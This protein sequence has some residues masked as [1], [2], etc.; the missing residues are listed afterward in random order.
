MTRGPLLELLR[1][2]GQVPL[3]GQSGGTAAALRRCG[4]FV[5]VCNN[6]SREGVGAADR[7]VP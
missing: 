1:G 4:L 2:L 3:V 5:A 7:S 6:L